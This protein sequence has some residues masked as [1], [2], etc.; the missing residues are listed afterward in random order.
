MLHRISS[1]ILPYWGVIAAIFF[2]F[3]FFWACKKDYIEEPNQSAGNLAQA[4]QSLK[5]DEERNF[6]DFRFVAKNN[7]YLRSSASYRDKQAILDSLALELIRQNKQYHFSRWLIPAVGYPAWDQA[8]YLRDSAANAPI[9]VLPFATLK[10][11]SVQAFLLASPRNNL[12]DG[13][14]LQMFWRHQVDSLIA[15]QPRDVDNLGFKVIA[16]LDLDKRLFGRVT[17]RYGR[18]LQNADAP[19]NGMAA[20]DRTCCEEWVEFDY[21]TW[22]CHMY[23]R[24]VGNGPVVSPTNVKASDRCPECTD[25]G[26]NDCPGFYGY[27]TLRIC[28]KE[29]PTEPVTTTNPG[30]PGWLSDVPSI[31]I[32]P[33]TG[34]PGGGGGGGTS[35]I[36]PGPYTPLTPAGTTPQFEDFMVN[37]YATLNPE[38]GDEFEITALTGNLLTVCQQLVRIQETMPL[39]SMAQLEWYSHNDGVRMTLLNTIDLN[40]TNEGQQVIAIISEAAQQQWI[41]ADEA[42]KLL[43]I[44]AAT[45]LTPAQATWL[46]NYGKVHINSIEKFSRVHDNESGVD[47][48]LDAHL[49]KLR[50]DSKYN[51]LMTASYGWIGILWDICGEFLIRETIDLAEK[52]LGLKIGDQIKDVVSSCASGDLLECGWNVFELL[53][54]NSPVGKAL[55]A[56]E[57]L[58]TISKIWDKIEPIQRLLGEVGEAALTKAWNILKKFPYGGDAKYLKYV[59]R[60]ETPKLGW[61]TTP[62]CLLGCHR[63][64]FFQSFPELEDNF[65]SSDIVHHAVPRALPNKYPNIGIALEQIESI[66]NYRGIKADVILPNGR[67]LHDEITHHRWAP[68]YIANPNATLSDVLDYVRQ[69]DDEFGHLFTPPIR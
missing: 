57:F 35:P 38:D 32:T 62:P 41:T 55:N 19:A 24:P 61:A 29:C 60:L 12:N 65:T 50:T 17:A 15:I 20:D 53:A 47:A 69:I 8:L 49:D 43:K 10:A 28:V 39:I 42:N 59:A 68:W 66:E 31:I 25:P 64:R 22:I 14:Y 58:N 30:I 26:P 56:L 67:W 48:Y 9:I 37:C 44:H 3:V 18:W 7:P 46:I 52:V 63:K 34:L 21:Y 5:T 2:L 11:D 6:F 45:T 13:W 16:L 36:S 23:V 51:S 1:R 40:K 54:R 4:L 33:Y 27:K